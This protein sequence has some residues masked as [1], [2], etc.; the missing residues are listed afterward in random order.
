MSA[1][2]ITFGGLTKLNPCEPGMA[3][4]RAILP[5][6]RPISAAEAKEAGVAFSDVLWVASE[7]AKSDT[8]VA[9][10]LRM[11]AADCAA[12]VLHIYESQSTSDAPRRAI[13]AARQFANGQIDLDDVR[14]NARAASEA[15]DDVARVA[16]SAAEGAAA[17][18]AARS[19]GD[20]R[21]AVAAAGAARAAAWT[22]AARA[23]AWTA[24]EAAALSAGDAAG[25]ERGA[26]K[27]WQFDRLCLWLSDNEPEPL[28][29]STGDPS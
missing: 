19:A 13:I 29:L 23:A 3:R 26:E 11:W 5:K 12:H 18:A 10:R 2:R 25:A 14:D 22:A 6:G 9:R 1:P 8:S 16:A 28:A 20:A 27:L 21:G 17:R 4:A 7:M 15:A 24:A